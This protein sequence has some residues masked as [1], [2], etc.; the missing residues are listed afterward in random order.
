MAYN[1]L[2][3]CSFVS[4]LVI[5]VALT[6]QIYFT[7]RLVSHYPAGVIKYNMNDTQFIRQLAV[8]ALF[9]FSLPL[10]VVSLCLLLLITI[11]RVA[12]VATCAALAFGL[13]AMIVCRH[14][15][16]QKFRNLVDTPTSTGR[17]PFRVFCA[18][19]MDGEIN[20]MLGSLSPG[21][22]KS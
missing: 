13:G 4:N 12:A 5:T 21:G 10:F 16:F 15:Y 6:L 7:Q 1:V 22:V 20:K 14:A 8:S 3:G 18:G 11:Y 2:T 17:C 19:K 9:K